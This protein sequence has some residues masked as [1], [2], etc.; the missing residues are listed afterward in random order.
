MEL[1]QYAVHMEWDSYPGS[2]FRE[3]STTWEDAYSEQDARNRARSKHGHNKGFKIK[4]VV[5]ES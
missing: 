4:F 5:K 1:K 3:T 2:T